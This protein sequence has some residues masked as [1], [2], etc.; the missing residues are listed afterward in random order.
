MARETRRV[1]VIGSTPYPGAE[2]YAWN[3]LPKGLSVADYDVVILDF[4]VLEGGALPIV[5]TSNFPMRE[6][7]A[8]L[9]FSEGGEVLVIGT[10]R[11][12]LKDISG[13]VYP[14][15]WWLPFALDVTH[16]SGT[17]VMEVDS[18]VAYLFEHVSRWKAFVRAH[19]SPLM[20][21]ADYGRHVSLDATDV[22][23]EIIPLA[24]TRFRESVAFEIRMTLVSATGE[25]RQSGPVIWVPAVDK[26][27]STEVVDLVLKTRYNLY[28]ETPPPEW[29]SAHH[30]PRAE[31]VRRE[32]EA[33]DEKLRLLDEKRLDAQSRFKQESRFI[34]LLY[35]RSAA[36]EILVRD[37]FRQ[38]GAEVE[39]RPS[40]RED[41]RLVDPFGRKAI[42]EIKGRSGPVKLSDIRQLQNWTSDAIA[43]EGWEGKGILVVNAFADEPV[44]N[45]GD[46]FPANS[47]K[48]AQR[49]DQSLLTS[50]Q[51]FAALVSQQMGQFDP[52]PFWDAVF[53][54]VGVVT[55]PE[56]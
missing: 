33:L 4:Q 26:L 37:A 28:V 9:L 51:L 32:L 21:P 10:P 56:K 2:S 27:Q 48:A 29:S 54:A 30:L 49:F 47:L 3:S 38:L 8:R 45:R 13:G 44:E 23:Y 25:K 53:N 12:P 42:F 11:L 52:R 16:E 40:D 5:N 31:E 1:I 41:G 50:V 34:A 55:I 18:S 14:N 7:F 39:E 20:A 46:P 35:E 22:K 36:L 19:V 6:Q 15:D 17:E 24:K 43:D